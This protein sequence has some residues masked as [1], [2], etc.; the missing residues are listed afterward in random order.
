MMQKTSVEVSESTLNDLH[1][2]KKIYCFN[3]LDQT[4]REM[5]IFIKYYVLKAA[6]K[7]D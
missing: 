4:I 7:N 1:Q 2:I 6:E 3:S 5:I